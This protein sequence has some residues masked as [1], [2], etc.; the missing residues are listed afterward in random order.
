[1]VSLRTADHAV[2]RSGEDG[3]Q[4]ACVNRRRPRRSRKP[5]LDRVPTSVDVAVHDRTTLMSS[6]R[7]APSRRFSSH[8]TSLGVRGAGPARAADLVL[9]VTGP[10][11]S[12]AVNTPS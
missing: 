7:N 6:E 4:A 11:A 8:R 10:S 3:A 9:L 12:A 2:G 1:V 5:T